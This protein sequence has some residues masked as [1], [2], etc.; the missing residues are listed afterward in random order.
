MRCSSNNGKCLV[1][2]TGVIGQPLQMEKIKKGLTTAASTAGSTFDH[3]MA[4]AEG[5]MTTDTFPKLLS[6]EFKGKSKDGASF[7]YR[8][9]GWSKGAGMIH[10]N[11][12]TMLS[13]VFTDFKISANALD[14]ACK[15]A[16]DRSF[17]AIS[18]D[19]DTSTNDTFAIIANGASSSMKNVD[20]IALQDEKQ[21]NEFQT[22]LTSFA[23][24][25]AKLI[26]RDGE[27]ATKFVQVKISV[28]IVIVRKNTYSL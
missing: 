5:I 15:Y 1:M 22:N 28:R 16:A 25:L 4:C 3:W 8:M 2:S 14:K 19:G 12:A 6:K 17:N 10:P 7:T 13:A 24:D 26:V 27:G 20:A 9:A 18:I 21:F 23:T 11:M